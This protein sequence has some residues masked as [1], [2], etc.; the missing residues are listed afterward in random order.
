MEVGGLR[1]SGQKRLTSRGVDLRPGNLVR[2]GALS[3]SSPSANLVGGPNACVRLRWKTS[4]C[5]AKRRHRL[6]TIL[7]RRYKCS[8]AYGW[9]AFTAQPGKHAV[10]SLTTCSRRKAGESMAP[11]THCWASQQ[12]HPN[13]M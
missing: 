11:E 5:C 7:A 3:S 4:R 6:R 2:V 12:W 9:H 13:V 10:E 1:P 8:C